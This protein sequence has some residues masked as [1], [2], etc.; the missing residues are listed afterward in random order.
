MFSDHWY[1]VAELKPSLQ[2]QVQLTRHEYRGTDW[3]MLIDPLTGN[4]HRLAAAAHFIVARMNGERTVQTI[5]DASMAELDANAPTQSEVIELLGRLHMANLLLTDITPDTAALFRRARESKIKK[6]QRNILNPLYLRFPLA[7]PDSLLERLIPLGRMI[8]SGQCLALW[9]A[10][11]VWGLALVNTHWNAIVQS[12]DDTFMSPTNLALMAVVFVVMKLLH[13]LAHGLAVKRWGGEVHDTGIV[14]LVLL[15]IPYV[16]ASSANAFADK[17]KRMYTSAAGIMLELFL[18]SVALSIWVIVEPGWVKQICANVMVI[19]AV[20]TLLFNGNPLLRFDGY[21]VLADY[22]EIPNLAGRAQSFLSRLTRRILVGPQTSPSPASSTSEAI[23]LF[24]YGIAAY[25]YRVVLLLVIALYLSDTF[26]VLGLLLGAWTISTQLLW[27][28]LKGARALMDLSD[29][30]GQR[31]RVY[32]TTAFAFTSAYVAFFI[33]PLPSTTYADGIVWLPDESVV[34]ANTDCFVDE[35]LVTP[36]AA[37]V[38]GTPLITCE[39]AV[40]KTKRDVL[41]AEIQARK[42]EY[43]AHGLREQVERKILADEIAS[44]DAELALVRDRL[45]GLQIVS[46]SAGTFLPATTHR[47]LGSF[48]EQGET[49]GY[50]LDEDR[51]TIKAAILQADIDLVDAGRA[52]EVRFAGSGGRAH[53]ASVTRQ[54]PAPSSRLPSAA[55]GTQGGGRLPVDSSDPHGRLLEE[56][57]YLV[58]LQVVDGQIPSLVGL[59]THIVFNN[60]AAPVAHHWTRNLRQLFMRQLDV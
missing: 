58:D 20:S 52:I 24:G 30:M 11:F 50:V 60:N 14:L 32:G 46:Q 7:D 47:L 53:M 44:I 31:L 42:M 27:P 1:R 25:A 16:D 29:N 55:L 43:R 6:R 2:S 45:K 40:L 12:I 3:W 22:L 13:E 57:V 38:A 54:V 56:P 49:L 21:Y 35:L 23:W 59:R 17:Y 10:T 41:H 39:N 9:L 19:G 4:Q 34:R 26:L 15:P 33:I 51:L 5:W 28:F 48:Y 18:A 36:G 8:F 37:V